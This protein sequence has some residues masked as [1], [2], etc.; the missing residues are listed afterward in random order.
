MVIEIIANN[1]RVVRAI[2][3]APVLNLLTIEYESSENTDHRHIN[4]GLWVI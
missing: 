4:D 3:P 2:V 1:R